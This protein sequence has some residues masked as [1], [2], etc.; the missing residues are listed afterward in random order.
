MIAAARG[1]P[2]HLIGGSLRSLACGAFGAAPGDL[3]F[4]RALIAQVAQPRCTVSA[5]G[6]RGRED[7]SAIKD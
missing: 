1:G 3:L 7:R 5:V 4:A 6:F 2:S